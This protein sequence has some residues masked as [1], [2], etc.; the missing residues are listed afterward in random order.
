MSLV[1][2]EENKERLIK[3]F[4]HLGV[5]QTDAI[6][7]ADVL[8]DAETRGI[9]SHGYRRVSKYVDCINSG[10]ILAN[11]DFKVL[12]DTPSMALVDGCGGLGIP[13]AVKCAQMAIDKAKET[14]VGIVSV[15]GSHHLGPAGY[16]ANMCAKENMLGMSMSNGDVLLAATGSRERT[17]GNNP[18]A[19]A[20]PAGKYGFISYDVA[21]SLGSDAKVIQAA[22]ENRL[23]PDGW[24]ID[25]N[26]RPTNDPNEYINGSPLLPFGSYKGYGL[27]LMVETF[28]AALS[29]SAMT[30]NVHAWNTKKGECGDVGHFFMA[31]D[32]AKIC[33]PA[34]YIARVENMIE[35]IASS[36]KCEGVDKIFYPGE[37]EKTAQAKCYESGL[38]EVD[39]GVLAEI[40]KIEQDIK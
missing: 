24:L 32:I 11:P 16:Y 20:V 8:T 4:T 25:R 29:G 12:V 21:I 5:S 23:L 18:F 33:D 2:I 27:A 13:V 40:E 19:Y 1:K 14:G 22:K 39:D 31:I 9:K 3:I 6:M 17:I 28:A 35:E 34:E 7:I 36:E 26:G 38:V 30:Q 10:G 15:K 37:I